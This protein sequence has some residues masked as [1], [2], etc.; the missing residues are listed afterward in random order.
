MIHL[1]F[2]GVCDLARVGDSGIR[3]EAC[4]EPDKAKSATILKVKF[5]MKAKFTFFVCAAIVATPCGV[6]V[7]AQLGSEGSGVSRAFSGA[8]R[9]TLG[10]CF[11][12]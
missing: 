4:I 9:C 12:R 6:T 8:K 3:S 10:Y 7:N 2:G 5:D 11:I 1:P